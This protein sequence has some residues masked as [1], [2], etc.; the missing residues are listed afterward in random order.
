MMDRIYQLEMLNTFE[1]G[2]L[3][4]NEAS[5]AFPDYRGIQ[6]LLYVGCPIGA[7]DEMGRTA[8]HCAIMYRNLMLIPTLIS[9]GAEVNARDDRGMT[10]LHRAAISHYPDAVKFLISKGADIHIKDN[11][12]RTAW[13]WVNNEFREVCPELEPK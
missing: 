8:L 7:R 13:D 6:D 2:E 10:A 4:L 5:S 1:L 12:G 9:N 11:D 3:L